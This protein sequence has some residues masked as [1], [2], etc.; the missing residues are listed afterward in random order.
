MTKDFNIT[1]PK[2]LPKITK[3]TTKKYLNILLEHNQKYY[4]KKSKNIAKKQTK[5]TTKT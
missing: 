3:H 4:Q 5:N 2:L 1:Q